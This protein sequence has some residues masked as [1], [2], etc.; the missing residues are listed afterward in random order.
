MFELSYVTKAAFDRIHEELGCRN[1]TIFDLKAQYAVLEKEKDS[2][3][4]SQESE[5]HN[6]REKNK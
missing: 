1:Q 4:S 5:L 6:L 2:T 3:I